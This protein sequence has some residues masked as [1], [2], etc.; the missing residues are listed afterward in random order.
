M[1]SDRIKSFALSL[2]QTAAVSQWGGLVFKVA[3]KV[4]IILGLDGDLPDGISL[5]CTPEEFDS[6]VKRAGFGLASA[7]RPGH[8]WDHGDQQNRRHAAQGSPP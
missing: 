6:L 7:V 8:C 5:K 1:R 4:F 3:G 2:P